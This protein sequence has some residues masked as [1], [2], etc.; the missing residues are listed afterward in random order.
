MLN[1]QNVKMSNQKVNNL[2]EEGKMLNKTYKNLINCEIEYVEDYCKSE[3]LEYDITVIDETMFDIEI[4]FKNEK[5]IT[6]LNSLI[7]ET[8]NKNKNE[9]EFNLEQLMNE[10]E[11]PTFVSLAK[12]VKCKPQYLYSRKN[13]KTDKY[14]YDSIARYL[15]KQYKLNVQNT[16][17]K[18]ETIVSLASE[19]LRNKEMKK[20]KKEKI[21]NVQKCIKQFDKLQNMLK[22]LNESELDL[23]NK[24]VNFKEL[25]K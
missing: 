15:I 22:E 12:V 25:I 10:Y 21:N 19:Y 14:N 9:S 6:E 18:I 8:K 7:D 23:F 13:H 1:S 16:E 5:Q 3:K 4:Q 24:T 2:K 20:I 11:I 17:I